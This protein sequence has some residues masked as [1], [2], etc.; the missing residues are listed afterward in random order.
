M[1]DTLVQ[2]MTIRKAITEDLERNTGVIWATQE[3]FADGKGGGSGLGFSVLGNMLRMLMPYMYTTDQPSYP[4]YYHA[5][6]HMVELFYTNKGIPMDEDKTFNYAGRFGV[7]RATPGDKHEFYIATGEITSEM[8]FN[9]EPRFY[10]DLVF[11]RG[12]YMELAT[13]TN[14]GGA[15]FSPPFMRWRYGE[16][17]Q[18]NNQASGMYSP[19]KNNCF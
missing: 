7:R 3:A 19:K 13:A 17:Q 12:G 6:W 10:A 2:M 14:N 8:H 18:Q 15:T 5:S 9:R 16:I 1:N 4:N 11:D